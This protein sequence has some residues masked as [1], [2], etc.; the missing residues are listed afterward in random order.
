MPRNLESADQHAV[1][2]AGK[3][4]DVASGQELTTATRAAWH[5]EPQRATFSQ[6]R[7]ENSFKTPLFQEQNTKFFFSFPKYLSNQKTSLSL[8]H[9]HQSLEC[10]QLKKLALSSQPPRNL[11]CCPFSLNI[12][13]Q[14][15]PRSTRRT[16]PR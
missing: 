14:P 9:K 10:C 6:A 8:P 1:S 4:D 2:A 7:S 3:G 12:L 5:K 16:R 11:H 13:T 15:H